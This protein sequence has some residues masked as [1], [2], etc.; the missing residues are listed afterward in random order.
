MELVEKILKLKKE[1]NAVILVHNYQ[2]P[3]V[4][5]IA[6]FVGDSLGLSM[7]ASRTNA[8]VIIFCGV[9]FMAETASIIC[10]NKKVIL[11]DIDAGCPMADM[12]TA[13][14]LRKLKKENPKAIVVAYVNTSAE[15]KAESDICCTS[16][17]AEKVLKKV[18]ADFEEIIFIPDK[19]LG[20]YAS[21]GMQ[22]KFIFWQ[23]YCPTHVVILEE[24][25]KAA[26]KEHPKALVLVHPECRPEVSNIADLAAST[27]GMVK[28]ARNSEAKEFIIGTEIGI[29]HRLRKENPDKEFYPATDKAICPNM[30]KINLEKVL[31]SLE[32]MKPEVK[33]PENIRVRA[34]KPVEK[35]IELK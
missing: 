24:D 11:P 12:I 35:M 17:N 7:E 30:K 16:A 26:K 31:W 20:I 22:K 1:R 27:E 29:I 2:I 14:E 9:R 3:E 23:G 13:D 33:V 15:V 34:V 25:I 32:D 28:F 5:D 19:Y 21:K 18:A 8:D 6:D 10:Q 4:Q